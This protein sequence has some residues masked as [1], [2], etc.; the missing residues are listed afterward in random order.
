MRFHEDII[1]GMAEFKKTDDKYVIHIREVEHVNFMLHKVK[2]VFEFDSKFY[3][4]STIGSEYGQ[5]ILKSRFP[6]K[7]VEIDE[8]ADPRRNDVTAD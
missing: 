6:D 5:T 3:G 4:F 7:T 2:I 8:V 1:E